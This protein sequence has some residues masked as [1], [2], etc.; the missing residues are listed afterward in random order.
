MMS[1]KNGPQSEM[2]AIA[3]DR[4]GHLKGV[5]GTLKFLKA[6]LY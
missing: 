2:K 3:M 1:D 5:S 6:I 4:S